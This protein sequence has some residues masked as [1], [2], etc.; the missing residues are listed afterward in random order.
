MA[1]V[2]GHDPGVIAEA[3]DV[4]QRIRENREW[5]GVHYASDGD[6]GAI[7]ARSAFSQ[8]RE[9]FD[10]LFVEAI[11][12]VQ[13]YDPGPSPFLGH[14]PATTRGVPPPPLP[15]VEQWSLERMGI[16]AAAGNIG[17]G[18]KGVTVGLVDTAVDVT[19]PTFRRGRQHA[20]DAA[21]AQ[22]TDPAVWAASG[23]VL[24]LDY[25]V[26]ADA[27]MAFASKGAGHGTAMGG[28]IVGRPDPLCPLWG[29]AP[30]AKLL[31][32]RCST[33]LSASHA[34]RLTLAGAVL[35]LAFGPEPT[36]DVLLVGPPFVRP[37]PDA[38][39]ADW[40]GPVDPAGF[41]GPCDPLALAI[42]VASLA[43]PVVIP[44]GNDGTSAISYPGAPSDFAPVAATLADGDGR[45]AVEAMLAA[46]GLE[47]RRDR[48]DAAAAAL[49]EG[50]DPFASTGIIVVGAARLSDPARKDSPLVPARYSQHGP[51]LCVLAPSDR[52]E[53]AW[54]RPPADGVARYNYVP[55]PDIPGHG[56]Y[57]TDPFA[58]HSHHAGEHG[59]GGTS[60]AAAQAA[61]VIARVIE[62]RRRRKDPVT[63]PA[64]RQA[65]VAKL[66]G[67]YA[68]ATGY[69]ILTVSV[70]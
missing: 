49:A 39:P 2:F 1:E 50:P 21:L 40:S 18:G 44:S 34:N 14:G 35:R 69:G 10:E 51:G 38:Y 68:P 32:V 55:A 52:D 3:F 45:K 56:G 6:C 47:V 66:S 46:S 48:L 59:F 61:G 37:A 15:P 9:V 25:P 29:A 65:V 22:T 17:A 24:N 23:S 53:E 8:L 64:V 43:I 27:R 41:E 19:H 70:V 36:A 57:A 20:I 7:I 5:A 12:D 67:P 63:G 60:A 26:A 54:V 13:S 30:E 11:A 28:L 58:L 42:L 16:S 33:L 4:A 31:P 62:S